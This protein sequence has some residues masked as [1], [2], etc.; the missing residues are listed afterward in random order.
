MK[1]PL[2]SQKITL[3]SSAPSRD[4]EAGEELTF[5]FA[6]PEFVQGSTTTPLPPSFVSFQPGVS[7]D[8]VYAIQVDLARKGLRRHEM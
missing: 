1:T 8:I 2:V 7:C 4:C 3:L 6:F 5:E